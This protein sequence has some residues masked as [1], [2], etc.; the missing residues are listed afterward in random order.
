[1][2][3]P[4]HKSVAF[5]RRWTARVRELHHEC[6][7]F[8]AFDPTQ[9]P[10]DQAPKGVK[11]EALW[12][13]GA[14][15]SV[16]TPDVVRACKLKPTGKSNVSTGGGKVKKASTYL[17]NLGLPNGVMVT[18]TA[19]CL[20]EYEGNYPVIIGMDVISAGDFALS[21]G[22]KT[23]MSYSSPSVRE[24]DFVK[25]VRAARAVE[26]KKQKRKANKQKNRNKR[27]KR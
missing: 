19:V 20:P 27:R 13:T 10:P 3:P 21:G 25:E 18:T 14:T 24:I 23:M 2:N 6:V 11:F 7:V 16:V 4:V 12:D 17:V 15:S 26:A 1:M 5:T 8:P 9:T 22:G